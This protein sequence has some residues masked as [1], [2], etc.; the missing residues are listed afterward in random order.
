[1]TRNEIKFCTM[2]L[3]CNELHIQRNER[4]IYKIYKITVCTNF[5]TNKVHNTYIY[6]QIPLQVSPIYPGHFQG[7]TFGTKCVKFMA[8]FGRRLED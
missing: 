6:Y 3:V 4:E 7:G 5:T 2:R 8:N 1:M